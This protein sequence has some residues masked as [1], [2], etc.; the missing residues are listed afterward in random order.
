MLLT[1]KELLLDAQ[2]NNYAVGAFNINNMEIIQAIIG[3]AEDTKSPVIL[4][5]SQEALI[6]RKIIY[7]REWPL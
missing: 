2:K 6:T 1:G 3:A 7:G 5:A 4:Q